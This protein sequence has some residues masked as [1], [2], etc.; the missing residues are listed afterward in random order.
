MR[1]AGG[2]PR[3]VEI[4]KQL[5]RFLH[6]AW[7]ARSRRLQGS[8]ATTT[9]RARDGDIS[10]GALVIVHSEKISCLAGRR[11]GRPAGTIIWIYSRD[12]TSGER[13]PRIGVTI[14]FQRGLST[15]PRLGDPLA[16]ASAAV[17]IDEKSD[18]QGKHRRQQHA[19]QLVTVLHAANGLRQLAPSRF[20]FLVTFL[21]QFLD[22]GVQA[23]FARLPG[24]RDFLTVVD[25]GRYRFA[26]GPWQSLR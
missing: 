2:G 23:A 10:D 15:E 8:A 25:A 1:H 9:A 19:P 26:F 5:A 22:A 16:L 12:R 4:R 21:L 7:K 14:R 6:V 3:I 13:R 17:E 11:C 24:H 18:Q 20:D